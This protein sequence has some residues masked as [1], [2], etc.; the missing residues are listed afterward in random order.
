MRKTG[1]DSLPQTLRDA[2]HDMVLNSPIPAKAQA[3]ELG[4][5]LS[6]LYN[7]ANPQL[8]GFEYQL[9]LLLQH[10]RITG[11]FAALD[12][13]E[14]SLGR[15]AVPLRQSERTDERHNSKDV[16][17]SLLKLTAELGAIAQTLHQTLTDRAL[18]EADARRA[19]KDTWEIVKT[20]TQLYHELEDSFR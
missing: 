20:T 18:T 1:Q 17:L 12:F 4:V 19:R 3:E 9:R 7:A 11:N 5:P 8:E 16:I 14:R 13:L 15:V 10:I 2:L 6:Y